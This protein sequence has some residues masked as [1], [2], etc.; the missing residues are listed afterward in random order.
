VSW[1]PIR[2]VNR[3]YSRSALAGQYVAAQDPNDPGML[4]VSRVA[5]AAVEGKRAILVNPYDAESGPAP[6]RKH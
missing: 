4:I 5:G 3:V 2:Y 1:A 6:S